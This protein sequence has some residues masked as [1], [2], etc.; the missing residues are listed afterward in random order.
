M[1]NNGIVSTKTNIPDKFRAT[2]INE[3][4]NST[5]MIVVN[6]ALD[7]INVTQ[8]SV[9]LNQLAGLVG[10]GSQGIQG[11]QG[12]QGPAGPTSPAGLEWRGAYDSGS[13]YYR[14]DVA[15]F[16]NP[17]TSILGSYWVTEAEVSGV[18][19][20][21]SQG[22]TNAGWAFLA[23]QGPQGIQGVQGLQGE[24]GPQGSPGAGAG[25][26]E[27]AFKTFILRNPTTGDWYSNISKTFYIDSL[28]L[29]SSMQLYFPVYASG[30]TYWTLYFTELQNQYTYVSCDIKIKP[31]NLPYP[32]SDIPKYVYQ[33]TSYGAAQAGYQYFTLLKFD[34]DSS[35]W[36]NVDPITMGEDVGSFDLEV[37]VKA[38]I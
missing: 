19:P 10:G 17:V 28:G 33:S 6:K 4:N 1:P 11:P 8:K 30:D 26:L 29:Q 27:T 36:V 31:Q 5:D 3:F 9:T 32:Y 38:Y 21:D 22:A 18:D 15:T 20:V 37:S 12:P 23:S 7:G 13:T 24:V 25:Y 16:T 34:V 35:S 14:N 2:S